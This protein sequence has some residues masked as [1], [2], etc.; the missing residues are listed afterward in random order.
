MTAKVL[1][2]G[3]YNQGNLGDDLMGAMFYEFL[4]ESGYSPVVYSRNPRFA[5][6]GYR[7]IGSL[8]GLDVAAIVLGGGAF[9]KKGG[10]ASSE[11]ETEIA[12]LGR[13]VNQKTVP[14]VG[15]S[16]GSDGVRRIED[17]SEARRSVLQS[18]HFRGAAVRLSTDLNIGL[19]NLTHI[20]DVVMLA[21]EACERYARLKIVN[22]Q[23]KAPDALINLSRR[24]AVQLPIALWHARKGSVAIFKAHTGPDRRGGEITVPGMKAIDEDDMRKSLGIIRASRVMISSKLHP[25]VLAMSF[26]RKFVALNARDKTKRFLEEHS[27]NASSYGLGDYMRYITKAV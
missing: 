25:G 24:T 9:L 2:W 13:F 6:M 14:V 18:P 19:P 11:I 17:V 22:P 10:D 3:F 20:P 1:V 23:E 12:N 7:S 21:N 26:G 4:E 16:I 15:V 5:A 8:E 27:R